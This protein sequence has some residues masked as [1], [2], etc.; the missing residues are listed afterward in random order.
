[1]EKKQNKTLFQMHF[2]VIA[3]GWACRTAVVPP[4]KSGQQLSDLEEMF[5]SYD[6]NQKIFKAVFPS[7][8][9]SHFNISLVMYNKSFKRYSPSPLCFLSFL[10]SNWQLGNLKQTYLK[11]TATLLPQNHQRH[12]REISGITVASIRRQERNAQSLPL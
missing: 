2:G 3:A 7:F 12:Q 1:M 9:K 10:F 8:H 5:E 6:C 4:Q 11:Q